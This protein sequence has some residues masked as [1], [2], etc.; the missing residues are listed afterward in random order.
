M[1]IYHCLGLSVIIS[2]YLWTGVFQV[3]STW[4]IENHR[5]PRHKKIGIH[6]FQTP[7]RQLEQPLKICSPLVSANPKIVAIVTRCFHAGTNV[8]EKGMLLAK[9]PMLA[10]PNTG[11]TIKL[12]QQPTFFQ[13][14]E[15]TKQQRERIHPPSHLYDSNPNNCKP[16]DHR[17]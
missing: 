9:G 6:E 17:W 16:P 14:I 2:E 12:S 15:P 7:A 4:Q 11:I 10:I 5:M 1:D 8:C 3:V 13:L